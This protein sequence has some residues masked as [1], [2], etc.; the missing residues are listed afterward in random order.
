MG[1]A[2]RRFSR[3]AAVGIVLAWA[4]ASVAL[5][6]LVP[7]PLA[8]APDG[9]QLYLPMTYESQAAQKTLQELFPRQYRASTAVVVLHRPEGLTLEDL[10]PSTGPVRR[11]VDWIARPALPPDMPAAKAA[12]L[13]GYLT[14]APVVSFVT[15]PYLSARLNSTDGRTTLV[16][17]GMPDIFTARKTQATVKAIRRQLAE[18][19][20][21][22]VGSAGVDVDGLQACVTGDAGFYADYNDAAEQSVR[23]STWVTVIL[24]VVILLL[25]YRS[26]VAMMVPLVT[27]AVGVHMAMRVLY[28]LA[29]LGFDAGSVVRMF[30]VVVLFGS[31]TDY[32]LFIISRYREESE[33][34]PAAGPDGLAGRADLGRAMGRAWFGTA[35]AIAASALTTMAGLSLMALAVFRAF[36]KAGPSVAVA[37]GVGC[38]ASLTLAPALYL[39]AGRLLFW[40]GRHGAA[41]DLSGDLWHR[42]AAGVTRRPGLVTLAVLAALALPSI[43]S[44]GVR[45]THNIFDELSDRW[46]SVRGFEI[47]KAGY[48]PGSMGP[49]TLLVE[50]DVPLDDGDGW[51]L[52]GTLAEAA[53]ADPAVADVLWP[54]RPLGGT[55]SAYGSL[56]DVGSDETV[57]R[58]ERYFFSADARAARFEILF[59][60]GPYTDASVAAARRLREAARTAAAES[61]HVQRVVLAGPSSTIA[62]I[63]EVA[64]RDFRVAAAAVLAAVY[65]ILLVV[66]RRPVLGLF[67]I[68]G[69]VL[70]FM[71]ALGVADLVFVG[72]LGAPGLDWKI[73][74]FLLVLL[75]AVGVDYNIYVCTRIRQERARRPLDEAVGVAL[76]RTGGIVSA[77]GIIVAGTFASMIAGTLSL[78]VQLGFAL[79]VG[80]LVDTFLVRPLAVPAVALM[81]ARITE[82]RRRRKGSPP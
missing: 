63:K 1:D 35:A 82:R 31:G 16:L 60:E 10:N 28:L 5:G 46:D 62:D 7:G 23:N 38:A 19:G 40:P 70:S 45:P 43:H 29:P 32:C 67:L 50:A 74:F 2:Q 8:E 27:I 68:G 53:D 18:M 80:I 48:T 36:Q 69:T 75:V 6:L 15:A 34:L 13:R 4:A 20:L 25:V 58:I 47:L 57:E 65:V 26:P 11:L 39:L 81:L 56:D 42:V 30:V 21:A 41:R 14:D 3:R 55:G 54:G 51:A 66:L 44:L 79:A 12:E 24:V 71:T 49:A 33:S 17:V 64:R 72:L 22:G 59:F 9:T 76:E 77:C 78:T 37:L 73:K 61:P 52:L